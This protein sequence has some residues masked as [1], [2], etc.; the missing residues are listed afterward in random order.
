MAADTDTP[1]DEQLPVQTLIFLM[2][3]ERIDEPLWVLFF[4]QILMGAPTVDPAVGEI[5]LPSAA[6]GI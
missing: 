1:C 4:L 6:G 3:T 2:G 5:D